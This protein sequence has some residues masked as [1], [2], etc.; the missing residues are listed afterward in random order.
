MD[1]QRNMILA[2]VFSIALLFA[3][4]YYET[5]RMEG[6]A[7]RQA[8][9]A[10]EK[11]PEPT[12][13]PGAPAAAPGVPGAPPALGGLAPPAEA[14]LSR[15]AVLALSARVRIASA[16]LNGSIALAGARIDD[17]TLIDYRATTDPE[18]AADPALALPDA[19]TIWQ[20]DGEVLAPGRPVTLR[21]DNGQGLTFRRTFALDDDYMFTVTDGVE[22]N[23]D[24][25]VTLF[26]Y[27]LVSRNGT[28][29]VLGFF[30]LH[31]GP[32]GVLE[33]TLEEI[34]YDDLKETHLI[35]QSTTGGWIGITDKYWL[36]ALVPDQAAQVKTHFSYDLRDGTD[37]YQADFRGDAQTVPAGGRAEV[38]SRLF[39]GAK[40]VRLLDRYADELGID[41]FDLAVD[42]GWFYFLTKPIFYL[43]DYFNGLLG[44]FGLAILLLTVL[45][46]LAF[47][48]LANKSYRA[49]GKMK[50]LQPEML[51]LREQFKDDR[52]RLNQ[53]MMALYKREKVNPAAG[54]LPIVIQI[55]VF[56][57][58]YKVLFVTIE[59]RHAPFYGWIHDLS[60]PDPLSVFTLFGLI[61][62]DLPSIL[63]VGLWP[64]IMGATWYLQQK[65]NPQPADPV[66]AKI[67]L[68][69]PIVFTF[70]LARFPAGLVIYWAWN[71]VLSV[72][73][74]WVIMR[75]AAAE[76]SGASGAAA[77]SASSKA[78]KGS[79]RS[80]ASKT[81]GS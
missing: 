45:I 39:A 59:M 23:R 75:R 47:F 9:E 26:P 25:A 73:Q 10:A 32:V 7:E 62:V 46:K 34:D 78:A 18:S 12:G 66:Q 70:L 48:P 79:K 33:G 13:V 50:T 60:A 44:N 28:P 41:R 49:M 51:K 2:I 42:F 31:E 76:M 72:A 40:E 20:A 56:F 11:P 30:I 43:L 19:G 16:R 55:P 63:D 5:Q 71:N 29:S 36:V 77:P 14:A 3:W 81:S 64:V 68:F 24:Q 54:C 80:K 69:L 21:W 61:P 38:T 1:E 35:E 27:G 52:D 22:N 65:I 4:Q 6:Q 58:L 53:E 17:V 8:Q 15:E 37:K 67:F 57:A 74:Q